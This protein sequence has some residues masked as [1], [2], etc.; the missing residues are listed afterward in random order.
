MASAG[1]R[2]EHVEHVTT[3]LP[4]ALTV[5][6]ICFVVYLLAGLIH[7]SLVCLLFGAALI[8]GTLA[9]I[10]TM[11]RKKSGGKLQRER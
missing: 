3:Q 10:R 8:I 5:A 4:Y 2:I 7:N 6:G 1:A 9:V 11:I